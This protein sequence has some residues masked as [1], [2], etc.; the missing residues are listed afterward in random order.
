MCVNLLLDN[1]QYRQATIL[2]K[3]FFVLMQ[4]STPN[5]ILNYPCIALSEKVDALLTYL[6]EMESEY[7][8]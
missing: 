5:E 3:S 2:T 6:L 8:E 1:V 7:R 4:I